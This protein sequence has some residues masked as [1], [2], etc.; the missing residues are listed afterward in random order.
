M[1]EFDANKRLISLDMLRGLT[2]ALMIMVNNPGSWGNLYWPLAH[3]K[4]HG[5]TITDFVF[6]F[7]IFIVGVS[8]VLS[9]HKQL[10]AG[11]DKKKMK[12]KIW[13]R[14]LKIFGLGLFLSLWP[15]FNFAEL[16]IPGVLQRIAICYLVC[17]HI[18]LATNWKTQIKIGL[19][20]LVAYWLAMVLIP[21][22][23]LGAGIT[24]VGALL[25]GE[26]STEEIAEIAKSYVVSGAIIYFGY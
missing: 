18:F 17:A 2:I 25:D 21:V 19:G 16:R 20:A 5:V 1:K 13:I 10:A 15:K 4:W 11:A 9:T 12:K 26:I 7:F 8:I 3:A 14:S 23:G 22:P 6:P 24:A